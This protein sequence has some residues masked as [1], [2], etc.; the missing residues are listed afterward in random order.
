M[1]EAM[2]YGLPIITG[3]SGGVSESVVHGKT[4]FL[5]DPGDIET[6]VGHLLRLSRDPLE[7]AAIGVNAVKHVRENFSLLKEEQSL[8]YILGL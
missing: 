5:V 8:K 1:I 4:G 3:R 2:S 7:R 6:Y